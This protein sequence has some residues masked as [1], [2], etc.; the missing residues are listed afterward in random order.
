MESTLQ[1]PAFAIARTIPKATTIVYWII[2]VLFCLEMSFTAY[3]ELLPHGVQV[4]TR[5]GFANGYFRDFQVG[6]RP[7][8][9]RQNVPTLPPTRTAR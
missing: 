7:L 5:L 4:F 1:N 6:K 8:P 3:Y 9:R 2:T